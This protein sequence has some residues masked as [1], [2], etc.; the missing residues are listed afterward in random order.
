[1]IVILLLRPQGLFARAGAA[2]SDGRERPRRRRARCARDARWRWWELALLRGAAAVVA[3]AAGAG[4]AAQRDRDRRAVRD[5][6]RP[7]PRLRRHRLAR[8]RGVLRLRRLR[9]GAVR[10]ARDA[11]SAGSAWPSAIA[12][13]RRCSALLTQRADPARHRPDAA[14]GDARRRLDPL[15][16]RQ[17]AR[18][19]DR[20]RRRPAGRGDGA[21]SA[22]GRFDFDLARPRRLRLHAGRARRRACC[23]RAASCIRRS[24]SRCRRCATTG[25][26]P[27][28][29][30]CRCTRGWSRSTPSP[31]R[32][33]ARPARCSR[34]PPASPRSTCSTSTAPPTC[35]WCW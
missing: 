20:R 8:P 9:G 1:M 13:Q 14:D 33:P 19:A 5:V 27:R 25:C 34:R 35:C 21:V 16:A 30:A 15:R 6:A 32:S 23:S 18:L 31:R 22:F 4:A 17:Q 3:A 29:S 2:M 10:Q 24:A 7:D 28:A 26:A 11:R 12:R